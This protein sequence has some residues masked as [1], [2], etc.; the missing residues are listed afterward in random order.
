MRFLIC[1]LPIGCVEAPTYEQASTADYGSS[2]TQQDAEV[3]A[4][5]LMEGRLKDPYS[6]MW[7]CS[8]PQKGF[9]GDGKAWGSVSYYGWVLICSINS[10]NSYGAYIGGQEYHFLFINGQLRRVALMSSERGF[11]TQQIIYNQ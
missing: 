6:A 8:D 9:L 11:A 3:Q 2:I 1:L 10:K 7:Q 4:K 5:A